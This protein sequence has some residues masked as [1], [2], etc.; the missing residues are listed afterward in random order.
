MKVSY[1]GTHLASSECA[2]PACHMSLSPTYPSCLI[3]LRVATGVS[4]SLSRPHAFH[5]KRFVHLKLARSPAGRLSATGDDDIEVAV[6]RFTL[7][8]PGFDDA[9]IPRVVGVL[10][11]T[12]LVLNHFLAPQPV[13]AAQVRVEAL[14]ACLA[15][16]AVA[17]PSVQQRLE[18]LAPGRGR[19]AAASNV[20]GGSNVFAVA[21]YLPETARQELA[22]ASYALLKNAN[23]CGVFATWQGKI[24]MCRGILGS[25][26]AGGSANATLDA[27]T[28]A[29]Q[30][31]SHSFQSLQDR[32]AINEAGLRDNAVIPEGA[33]CVCIVPLAP[34]EAQETG[35]SDAGALILVSERERALSYKECRWAQGVASKLHQS[36]SGTIK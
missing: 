32:N 1:G 8:I 35:G 14:G 3:N 20:S 36:L 21:G 23:T 30:R 33:E 10:C 25:N 19:R 22:W 7:G 9:L 13:S 27:A 24:V 12:L 4:L 26:I 31:T 6:F 34:L 18:E 16:V 15:G 2:N 29:W 28:A 17:A 5:K 11:A